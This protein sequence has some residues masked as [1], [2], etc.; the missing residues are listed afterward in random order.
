MWT[1]LLFPA[2]ILCGIVGVFM[3]IS[4]YL[5]PINRFAFQRGEWG[6]LNRTGLIYWLVTF[7]LD[8]LG[9]SGMLVYLQHSELKLHTAIAF[10]V[11]GAVIPLVA[12]L[13]G[14]LTLLRK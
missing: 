12:V 4:P 3:T 14:V 9:Y 7:L 5:V 1:A 13:G 2:A 6:Y 10:T 11:V 8:V